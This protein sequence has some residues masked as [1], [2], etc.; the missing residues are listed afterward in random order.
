MLF[1]VN[2]AAI[3][4]H[5]PAAAIS[6][7]SLSFYPLLSVAQFVLFSEWLR[8]SALPAVAQD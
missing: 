2:F 4:F 3:Y 7:A 5:P 1:L 8:S 6:R